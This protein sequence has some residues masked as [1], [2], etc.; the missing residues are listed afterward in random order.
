MPESNAEHGL[1]GAEALQ[2]AQ[3]RPGANPEG[4]KPP[5]ELPISGE[6]G[7]PYAA[8]LHYLAELNMWEMTI[9]LHG[10]ALPISW[11]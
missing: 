7:D 6:P 10:S 11:I 1:F 8:P 2:E 9:Y 4:G 5:F 3:A